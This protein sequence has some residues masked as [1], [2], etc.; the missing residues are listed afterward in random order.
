MTSEKGEKLRLKRGTGASS[1]K[2]WKE[3]IFGIVEDGTRV[4]PRREPFGE[5]T[6][7]RGD[8]TLDR[9]VTKVQGAASIVKFLRAIMAP[10]MFTAEFHY[11]RARTLVGLFLFVL[12]GCTTPPPV[13]VVPVAPSTD[14][15]LSWI[16]RLEDQRKLADPGQETPS[17]QV[18]INISDDAESV[19]LPAAPPPRPDLIALATDGAP[20]LRR[21]AALAIGR[22]GLSDG[23]DTLVSLLSDPEPEVRQVAAFSLGLIGDAAATQP[24]VGALDDPSLKVQGRAAQAL[25]RIGAT[26]TAPAIGAMVQ[27]HITSTFELDPEDLSYPQRDEVEAFR[28][29]IYALGDLKAFDPLTDVVLGDGGQPILWWWPVAYALGRTEDPRALQALATLSGVQGSVGVAL[30]AQGLGA[31]NDDRA[32]QP[33][34]ELLDLNRRDRPVVLSAIRALGET[35]VPAAAAAL[36]RFVRIRSLDRQLRLA[37]VEALA[38]HTSAASIEVFTE[39]LAHPWPPLRAAALRAL[40]RTDPEGFMFVLSGLG[41]D[42][43]WRVRGALAEGLRWVRPEAAEYRLTLMLNDDDQ[44]VVPVVLESLVAV[45]APTVGRILQERL[46]VPDVVV[47]KT[48]ARLLGELRLPEAEE[49][50]VDAY[51]AAESDPSYLARA[52][53]L[54]ALAG[55]G[56]GVS[57]ATLRRALGDRDWAV[58]IRAAKHLE[59]LVPGTTHN[60]DIRPAPGLRRVDY[61]S[62][63]LINPSVS[64]HV[65]IETTHGTIEIEL[66]VLE[67]PL[68]SE[69]FTTLARQGFYDGLTFHRVVP[70]YVAQTGDPRSD[71]EGGPGYTLRDE[72]NELPFLRGTVGMARDW[73]DTGGSQ[74]FITYSPQPQFDGRYTAFGR[75][76]VGMDVVD[77]LQ[78]GD[79]IERVLVWDGVQPF[80]E[81]EHT[82]APR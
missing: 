57:T 10:A 30:A 27:R 19:A 2:I 60:D 36:D 66:A 58:R 52:A 50:L 54:D 21:R 45:G 79:F 48:A 78:P 44:R 38:N 39:L 62:S 25:S 24:L 46:Q 61:M 26:A 7:A 16:L 41:P 35:A 37:T 47:R 72:L 71:S 1:V 63:E 13:V 69:N 40:A 59:Q 28:L 11:G 34:T 81:V 3:R 51:A 49:A 80:G 15:Q 18:A 14:E 6:L 23:V 56:S 65:Y 67:A 33:L 22:V 55:Y 74:F 5:H 82:A 76:V 43:D 75:V 53:V 32:V 8:R 64:P 68:T 12:Y 29:G 17:V 20:Y 31:L 4:Q 42:P 77:Q 70:N 9:D 73:A